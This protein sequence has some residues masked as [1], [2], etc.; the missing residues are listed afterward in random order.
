ME[1][2]TT[3]IPRIPFLMSWEDPP[4]EKIGKHIHQPSSQRLVTKLYTFSFS[5]WNNESVKISDTYTEARIKL[6]G[7][8]SDIDTTDSQHEASAAVN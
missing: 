5:M 7:M 2:A 3:L 4:L 6:A 1:S 8:N